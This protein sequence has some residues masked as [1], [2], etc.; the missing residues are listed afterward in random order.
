MGGTS[1]NCLTKVSSAVAGALEKFFYTYGKSVASHP[2]KYI[3]GCVLLTAACCLGFANFYMENRPEKLWIPQDSD[4]VLTLN[5]QAENFPNDQRVELILYESDNILKADY[6]REMY[7]LRKALRSIVVQNRDGENVTQADL[8]FEVPALGGTQK[9]ELRDIK[10]KL[11]PDRDPDEDFDWSL[12]F[13][14]TIYYQFYEKMPKDC[15]EFSI[16]EIWGN[17]D[18]AIEELTDEE[19]LREINTANM[20]VT[21]AYPMDFQAFLGGIERDESGQVDMA[22]Y[23]WEGEFISLLRN[24]TGRPEGLEVYLQAQR[25]FGEISGETILGDVAFLVIGDII[26]FVYVQLMLGKFNMVETR[27]VLSLLGLLATFMAVGVSFG[28]CSAFGIAY[29]PVHSILPLLMLGLGVDDMFVIVQCWQ[30]LSHE[31]KRLELKKRMGCALRHAGVAIT[32]TSL[33][34]FAAFTIGASTVLPALRSFCIYSALGVVALYMLQATFFVAWFAL[35]QTR[36]EDHRNGLFWCY[37]HKNWTPNKCS[38][39]DL[40]QMFFDKIYSKYLLKKPVKALVLVVTAVVFGTSIWGV[41]NL[42]QEF[43]PV[44]F[45]PQSSYLFQFLSR[46]QTFYPEAGERGTV[47]LGALNYSQELPKIGYL[48]QAMRENEYI[49][50]VDSWYDLMID[51]TNKS[52][53]EDITGQSLNGLL[54]YQQGHVQKFLYATIPRLS[55]Q[56][57]LGGASIFISTVPRTSASKFDYSHRSLDGP[58]EQIPAMDQTKDLV[59]SANFSDFSDAGGAGITIADSNRYLQQERIGTWDR[60]YYRAQ[61]LPDFAAPIAMMYSSWETDKIIAFEL[62]RNLSLALVAVFVMTLILIA[63]I[64]SSIYVL[65][66][67]CHGPDDLVDLTIDTVSCINLVLCIGLCVDYSV[68]IALHFMQV[69]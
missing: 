12:A 51:Y 48:T 13:D 64:V 44:W 42:R 68:H 27:P 11:F 18:T 16:L 29:G 28:L 8:C 33:T 17:N 2:K 26:L 24:D 49:S 34:D 40:C 50:F 46:A 61:V 60:Y 59:K 43:N 41:T 58:S 1:G 10:R 20:S 52:T 47:Y 53:G 14:K 31:E 63:N 32:V 6:I 19:V 56:L 35:D 15:L 9:D 39:Y 37:K 55:L 7:R 45:I 4:Y 57:S 25:S 54:P 36:L 69:L 67:R 21:Y 5:W 66:C 22:L 38:Q 65:L 62:V 3:L 30:N 23:D